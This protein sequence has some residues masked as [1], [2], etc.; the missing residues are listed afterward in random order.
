MKNIRN[1]L[2]GHIDSVHEQFPGFRVLITQR[3]LLLLSILLSNDSLF[4]NFI[5]IRT[6][7]Q[8][9]IDIRYTRV[10]VYIIIHYVF[11]TSKLMNKKFSMS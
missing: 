7:V 8:L 9:Y 10:Y 1:S 11:L 3:R 6:N 4:R 5:L 2:S